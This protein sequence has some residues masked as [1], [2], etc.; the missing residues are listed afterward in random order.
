MPLCRP[1][2]SPQKAVSSAPSIAAAPAEAT[3]VVGQQIIA[4][5]DASS[6]KAEQFSLALAAASMAANSYGVMLSSSQHKCKPSAQRA[7]YAA[8]E[9]SATAAAPAGH[10]VGGSSGSSSNVLDAQVADLRRRTGDTLQQALQQQSST[11]TLAAALTSPPAKSPSQVWAAPR[12]QPQR[13]PQPGW[14]TRQSKKMPFSSILDR[15][16]GPEGVATDAAAAGSSVAPLGAQPVLPG[17]PACGNTLSL[18]ST[19][20]HR[21]PCQAV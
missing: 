14:N 18:I 21:L 13:P 1:R 4:T 8:G 9:T 16:L 20:Y 10:L 2:L 12:S 6:S 7:T 17:R 15:V 3:V 11:L 19:V 5:V